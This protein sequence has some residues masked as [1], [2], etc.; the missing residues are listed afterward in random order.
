MSN[1][2]YIVVSDFPEYA[3]HD[4]ELKTDIFPTRS[5]N[6]DYAYQVGL[7]EDFAKHIC[8]LLNGERLT[9]EEKAVIDAA[10][11]LVS[12]WEKEDSQYDKYA[13]KLVECVDLMDGVEALKAKQNES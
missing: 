10:K 1:Q 13:I 7:S 4:Q 6:R 2:R 8:D 5:G 12:R 11:M 3:I 9:P